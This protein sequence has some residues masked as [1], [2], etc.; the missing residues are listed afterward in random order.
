MF[1]NVN[2]DQLLSGKDFNEFY[3]DITIVKLT[4]DDEIHNNLKFKTGVNVDVL[5]F[6]PFGQCSSGGLYFTD[7]MKMPMWMSYGDKTM[8]WIRYVSI[9]DDA[10][11]YIEKDK[12]KCDKFVLSERQPIIFNDNGKCV[13]PHIG[14]IIIDDGK[15]V[16]PQ[17]GEII[18]D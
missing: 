14:E 2:S 9:P 12:F 8:K 17:S 4:K 18:I 6:S 3:G 1:L 5:P 11:V 10:Y 13:I 7:I 16:I 15:C